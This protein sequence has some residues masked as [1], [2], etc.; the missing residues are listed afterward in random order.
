MTLVA[1]QLRTASGRPLE[2]GEE[3]GRGGEARVHA[4]RGDGASA[5]KLYATADAERARKLSA[6]IARAPLD[7]DR[8]AGHVSIAW[9]R[10]LVLADDGRVVGFVMPRVDARRYLPLHQLYHPGS[11]RNRASGISWRYL[12]RIARNLCGAVAALHDADYVIGDLNESNVLVDD[13]ALVTLVDLDSIQVTSGLKTFRC[14]VGKGEYTPPELQGRSFRDTNRKSSSDRFGLAVLVFLLLME[15]NHPFAGSYRDEGEPPSLEENIRSRRSPYFGRSRLA[16]P[17]AAP[18]VELLGSELQSLLR[19]GVLG[20]PW[21]RPDPRELKEALGQLEGELVQCGASATHVYP[22]HLDS[23]PWCERAALLGRDPFPSASTR[24]GAKSGASAN[25]GVDRGLLTGGATGPRPRYGGAKDDRSRPPNNGARDGRSGVSTGGAA[26]GYSVPTV[27]GA[28]VG[29]GSLASGRS[30]GNGAP[31]RGRTSYGRNAA[32]T[33]SGAARTAGQ[34]VGFRG[35]WAQFHARL[36]LLSLSLLALLAAP[37]YRWHA[38]IRTQLASLTANSVA[39][40]LGLASLVLLPGLGLSAA[41]YR[42]SRQRPE[43]ARALIRLERVVRAGVAASLMSLLASLAA[44]LLLGRGSVLAGDWL[45]L[46]SFWVVA[47]IISLR[48]VGPSRP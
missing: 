43:F 1:G 6:M 9:P 32:P 23:C 33:S 48:T 16:P 45:L 46:P 29:R 38:E 44:G 37:S 18:P 15:G 12:V 11:R 19:R 24:S 36:P 7:P 14:N 2:L 35:S 4:I 40:Y 34:P 39:Q 42:R 20:Q 28:T 31:L 22:G 3:L 26:N 27:N 5:V 47:F 25:G 41:L 21:R 10:E 8:K 13:R 17:L 30:V